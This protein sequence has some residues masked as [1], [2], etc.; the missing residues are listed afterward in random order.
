MD[1]F[2]KKDIIK[3]SLSREWMKKENRIN[4]KKQQ[5]N[6]RYLPTNL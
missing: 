6:N 3:K 4:E 1:S 2:L 5:K